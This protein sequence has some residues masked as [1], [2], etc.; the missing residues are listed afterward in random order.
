MARQSTITTLPEDILEILQELLR[1]PRCSQLEAT[2]KINAI[3]EGRD[4]QPV[5]K[6]AVNRYSQRME[7][8]GA[9]LRQSREV[10]KMWIGRLGN[11][12]QGETGKLLNEIIRTLAFETTMHAAEGEE[13]VSPKMLK[14]L[15]L[16]V[17]RLESAASMNEDRE[18]KIKDEARKLA[19]EEAASK[20]EEVSSTGGMTRESVDLIKSEILG[21]KTNG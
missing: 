11:Q 2:A 5:S 18:K 9:R 16:A 15:A 7:E 3:L 1:D 14:D 13:P 8:V 10:A 6:S 12:P 4:E 19:L 17:Q 20:V 21:I